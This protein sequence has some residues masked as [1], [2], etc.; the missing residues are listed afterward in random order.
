MESGELVTLTLTA[1]GS[2]IEDEAANALA[3]DATATVTYDDVAAPTATITPDA[4]TSNDDPIVFTITFDEEVT[5]VDVADLSAS[6]SLGS[7][8][9]LSDFTAVS[10]TEY[11]VQ[12]SGMASGEEV[13][14]TLTASGSGIEDEATND[15]AADASATVTHED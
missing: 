11:T 4:A 7:T 9:T 15:L 2:G 3:N 13:T 6:G 8:L 1:S 12:V 10:A 14:L 5:G